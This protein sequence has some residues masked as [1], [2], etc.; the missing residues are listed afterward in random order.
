MR[1]RCLGDLASLRPLPHHA[2]GKRL[3]RERAARRI[4]RQHAGAIQSPGDGPSTERDR[5][6]AILKTIN[7]AEKAEPASSAAFP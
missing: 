2:K 3:R 7:L 1:A 6:H 4:A 5:M